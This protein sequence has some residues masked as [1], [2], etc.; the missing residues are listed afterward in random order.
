ML[1]KVK[2]I[3]TIFFM[4]FLPSNP[5]DPEEDIRV[6]IH[7]GLAEVLAV[8]NPVLQGYKDLQSPDIYNAAHSLIK[9]IKGEPSNI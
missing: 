2:V 7:E 5:S 8:L 6:V 3:R 9:M 1:L 4:I